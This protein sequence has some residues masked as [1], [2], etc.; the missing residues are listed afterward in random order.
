MT[1]KRV[2]NHMKVNADLWH[3]L[4]YNDDYDDDKNDDFLTWNKAVM[5]SVLKSLLGLFWK[6]RSAH[7]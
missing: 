1:N 2:R 4:L 3:A 5:T 6:I 7:K